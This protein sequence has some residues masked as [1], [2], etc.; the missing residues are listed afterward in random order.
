MTLVEWRASRTARSLFWAAGVFALIMAVIP[1][2]PQFPGEPYK[3]HHI[4]AFA[5]LAGL[6]SFAYPRTSLLKLLIGLSLYGA[7]I[8]IVQAMP[9][10]HRDSDM[11]DWLI[12]TAAVTVVLLLV[13]WWRARR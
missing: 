8:E 13:H 2:P 3:A 5:T 7:F 10:V 9:F 4:L 12:D 1:H 6:G 11:F